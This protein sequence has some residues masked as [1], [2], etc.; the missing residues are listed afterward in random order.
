[1]K[2]FELAGKDVTKFNIH[3]LADYVT[4]TIE[5]DKESDFKPETKFK[6][7]DSAFDGR[8]S[9]TITVDYVNSRQGQPEKGQ[10]TSKL[11]NKIIDAM[12]RD[13]RSQGL[14]FTQPEGVQGSSR[15][16][17]RFTTGKLAFTIVGK[18]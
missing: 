7:G 16:D 1:M 5:D 4:K 3:Q 8:D 2:L 17:D 11:F 10:N 9:C 13:F 18:E 15:E 12:Y 14:T 6:N